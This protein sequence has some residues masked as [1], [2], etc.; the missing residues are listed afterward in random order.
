MTWSSVGGILHQGGTVIG[1]ARSERFRSREG[2]LQAAENF[3]EGGHRQPGG[4][5]RRRKPHR[6]RPAETGVAGA[7]RG[8]RRL[9]RGGR[10]HG[11]AGAALQHR[12]PRRHDRQRHGGHRHHDRRRHGAAPDHGGDRRDRLHRREP[13]AHVR[14]RGHGPPLR[15]PGPDGRD[16]RRSELGAHPGEPARRGRLGGDD[17]RA[18]PHRPP[19]R[20]PRLDR[21]RGRGR[22]RP[23][24][25]PDHRRARPEGPAGAPQRGR[26][27]HDPR[28]RPAG[29]GAR[30]RSTAT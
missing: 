16:R 3:L 25:Q 19:G 9:R 12:G 22:A 4:D 10:R 2:R 29:R 28:P 17:V 1:T 30:A 26:A 23:L 21:G 11:G 8:A 7:R 20:P 18:P 15:L 27:R 14:G 5:R 24:R 6:R 13:P